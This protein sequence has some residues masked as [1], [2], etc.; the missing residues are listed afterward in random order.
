MMSLAHMTQGE[1]LTKTTLSRALPGA[2]T[3]AFISEW[4]QPQLPGTVESQ[5]FGR[6]RAFPL[7]PIASTFSSNW[8]VTTVPTCSRLQVERLASSSAMRMYTSYSGIRSTGGGAAPGGSRFRGCVLAVT[9]SLGT[10]MQLLVG[11]VVGVVPPRPLL[12]E[13]GVESRRHQS[14]GALLTLRGALRER[15]GVFVLGVAGMP[16]HP[17]P[18]DFVAGRRLHEFLPERQ[19]R[20]RPGE[21]HPLIRRVGRALVD[22]PARHAVP[23]RGLDEGGV[24]PRVGRLRAV[25]EAALIGVHQHARRGRARH[26]RAE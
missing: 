21:C 25:A 20:D 7:Y 17:A 24:A 8:S 23:G 13:P 4:M 5:R 9:P 26:L 6:P 3:S 19:S 1:A 14:V 15:I 10:L 12:G 18:R 16:T 22:V 2:L 11:V